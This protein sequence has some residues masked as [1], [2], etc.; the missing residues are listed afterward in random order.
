MSAAAGRTRRG[1]RGAGLA[2]ASYG[3]R[4]LSDPRIIGNLVTDLLPDLPRERSLLVTGAEADIAAELTQHV[5]EQHIDPNTAVQLVARSLV[6]RR[7]LDPAASMW[8]TSEY[9]QAL[10][11]QV[12][13]YPGPP[14]S[15]HRRV[16]PGCGR[17]A[18]PTY[19]GSRRRRT[20]RARPGRA[21]PQRRPVRDP[22]AAVRALRCRRVPVG[23]AAAGT[24]ARAVLRRPQPPGHGPC[25]APATASLRTPADLT[26][27]RRGTAA[28]SAPGAR[29]RGRGRHLPRRRR[30]R[31]AAPFS[32]SA[33]EPHPHAPCRRLTDTASPSPRRVTEYRPRPRR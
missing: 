23:P 26:R 10:G 8:V 2:V 27:R 20:R 16:N 7:S 33:P 21:V 3:Q 28:S 6:N 30:G 17:P 13:P 22:P 12:Q 5:Q 32:K 1:P 29:G 19:A 25:A 15:G 9:A 24:A 31:L 14:P 18:R 11:Y 4:V